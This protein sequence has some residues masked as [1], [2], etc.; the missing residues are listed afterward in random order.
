MSAQVRTQGVSVHFAGVKA[1]QDVDLQLEQGEILGLIGPNGAGKTTLVNVLSGYQR[2]TA[3]TVWLD[4][5]NVTGHAPEKRA[6]AGLVRTF[7]NVRLFPEL[8]VLDNILL[9]AVGTGR[10][11]RSGLALTCSLLENAGLGNWAATEARSLPYGAARRLGIARALATQPRFV[12]LDE[13]AAGL[14]DSESATLVESL[15][16]MPADFG[17][18]ILL[19]EHDM[20]VVMSVSQRI[21]VLDFGKTLAVGT[22]DEVRS[23]PDVQR[24]YFGRPVEVP[25]AHGD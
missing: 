4:E 25:H 2:P 21:H 20:H 8:T 19:I 5:R 7:Q 11:T 16:R 9:G 17:V 10:S 24:A 6:K 1:L 22:P 14:N 3:G 23:D 13:P 12:L 15:Q 18:G